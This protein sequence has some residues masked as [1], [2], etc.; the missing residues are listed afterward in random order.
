[1]KVVGV[2]ERPW[3]AGLLGLVI[4]YGTDLR[5][6]RSRLK[7]ECRCTEPVAMGIQTNKRQT[8]EAEGHALGRSKRE[9]HKGKKAR[10]RRERRHPQE[11]HAP[12]ERGTEQP[13]EGQG[14]VGGLHDDGPTGTARYLRAGAPHWPLSEG[15]GHGSQGFDSPRELGPVWVLSWSRRGSTARYAKHPVDQPAS[16][17]SAGSRDCG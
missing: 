12:R 5:R 2:V 6:G 10:P 7:G 17:S 3:G 15:A 14:G 13:S 11:R 1:M 8:K 9:E 4:S 16:L